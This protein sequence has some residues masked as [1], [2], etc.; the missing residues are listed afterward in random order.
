MVCVMSS[1]IG[2]LQSISYVSAIRTMAFIKSLTKDVETNFPEIA[3]PIYLINVPRFIFGIWYLCKRFLDPAV[4]AKISLNMG[5]P[6][7]KLLAELGAEVC[8]AKRHYVGASS[9]H[10]ASHTNW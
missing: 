8:R 2:D 1:D 10:C 3:G 7:E 5:V 6:K 4:E 9:R